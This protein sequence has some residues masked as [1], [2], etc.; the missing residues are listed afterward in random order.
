MA[1][2]KLRSTEFLNII[3][4]MEAPSEHGVCVACD[5]LGPQFRCLTCIGR[6]SFCKD[7]CI[8]AHRQTP[9]HQL[10]EWS[11]GHHKPLILR[12]NGF[13]LYMGHQGRQ[14]PATSNSY[15][16]LSTQQK[17]ITGQDMVIVDDTGVRTIFVV[18][19]SCR[20]AKSHVHQL[21]YAG[22][23]PATLTQPETAF[24]FQVL[25]HFYLDLM[26]CN[27]SALSFYSKLRRMTNNC[28]PDSV[29]VII[30]P[31]SMP[32]FY[33][34]NLSSFV[35]SVSRAHD[36]FTSVE[37]SPSKE[38]G[39]IWKRH[40]GRTGKGR[41]GC[42]L[43]RLSSARCQLTSGM[44]E[45]S[46]P[47]S[48]SLFLFLHMLLDILSRYKYR[49][50]V[51]ADGYFGAEHMKMRCPETDV[52]LTDGHDYF[53]TPAPYEGYLKTANDIQEVKHF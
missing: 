1:Q 35:G 33:N 48:Q 51:A 22:L 44:G 6:P 45:R 24:T 17:Q 16:P 38:V 41:F 7:C 27:T 15:D 47:V 37:L 36:C 23:Y 39:W 29:P 20:G 30:L 43:C 25:E 13:K 32:P 18:W 14:C 11:D 10:E 28:D 21:M 12:R 49:R 26:E 50:T 31:V 4:H 42:L 52:S 53:V 3:M 34:L 46:G 2:W 5:S 8:S 9:F 19:C 40:N